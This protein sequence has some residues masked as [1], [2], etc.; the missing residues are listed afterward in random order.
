M[1]AGRYKISLLV[2][3]KYFTRSVRSLVKYFSTLKEKFHTSAW[4]GN[5]F[6]LQLWLFIPKVLK[7]APMNIYPLRKCTWH[8]FVIIGGWGWGRGGGG[9]GVN[10]KWNN[11]DIF[12]YVSLPHRCCTHT[13]NRIAFTIKFTKVISKVGTI[14]L[15]NV[16][17]K[18]PPLSCA[19]EHLT[20]GPFL[21]INLK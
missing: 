4:P 20:R 1:A 14:I 12:V 6:Y 11:P 16:W 10:S 17:L 13:Y 18:Y 9:G 8:A 19:D 5:I 3:K 15:S 7:N 21:S 2:L